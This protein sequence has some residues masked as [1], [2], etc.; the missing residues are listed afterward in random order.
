MPRVCSRAGAGRPA[1]GLV[2]SRVAYE[3]KRMK[4][5][6]CHQFSR[7]YKTRTKAKMS[8]REKCKQGNNYMYPDTEFS[9]LR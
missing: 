3:G 6:S 5:A 2:V 8:E 9:S 4:E 1:D 7:V